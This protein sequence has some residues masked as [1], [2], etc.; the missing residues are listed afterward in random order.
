MK[1][2]E[3]SQEE[4]KQI[5]KNTRKLQ[6]NKRPVFLMMKK[7]NIT[8]LL[9]FCRSVSDPYSYHG[10]GIE[11]LAHLKENGR[12]VSNIW[13]R[14]FENCDDP[15][16]EKMARRISTELDIVESEKF[17]NKIPEYGHIRYNIMPS[18]EYLQ[19]C[20]EYDEDTGILT[21][22]VRPLHHF[23]NSHSMN[24][25]NAQFPGKKILNNKKG[26]YVVKIKGKYYQVN[27][28]VWKLLKGTEPENIIDHIDGDSLNNKIG[29]L[30]EASNSENSRN[31]KFNKT[32]K[33]GV[34]G[35]CQKCNKYQAQ[36]SYD[37]EVHSL[38]FY[39]TVEE[40]S[41]VYQ[42]ASLKHHGEFST[43]NVLE[44]QDALEQ[45]KKDSKQRELE[46]QEYLNNLKIINEN[47]PKG[48][49]VDN[50]NKYYSQIK[51]NGIKY[52][53]GYFDTIEAASQAYQ[54]ASLE[55]HGEFGEIS[56]LEYLENIKNSKITIKQNPIGITLRKNGKY[57]A[58][59][60]HDKKQKHIGYF[61]T[62]EEASQAYND[63][64]LK[65]RGKI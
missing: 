26:Y 60:Q 65:Y 63:A 52:W 42:I 39:D 33:L 30:R 47:R 44:Y 49:Y 58:K 50:R 9:Y 15:R 45:F 19:E 41:L 34:K 8:G 20:F 43:V 22:K 25:S 11:W 23:E 4:A 12:N 3:V 32:N 35:V 61:S 28:I 13:L 62:L 51:Y 53:L 6:K 59:I 27:R 14:K 5:I 17:A 2:L 10:S 37:G 24:V 64:A 29:N 38:G 55:C 36:I 48:V 7:H 46:H 1:K 16:L 54:E 31:V 56:K 18:Q 40:A 57:V 21:W